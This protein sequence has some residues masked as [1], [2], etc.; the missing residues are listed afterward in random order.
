MLESRA[1]DASQDKGKLLGR[2]K[3]EEARGEEVRLD[4]WAGVDG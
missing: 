4:G 2:S 1:G 3:G